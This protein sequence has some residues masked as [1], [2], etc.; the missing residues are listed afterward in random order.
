[1]WMLIGLFCVEGEPGNDWTCFPGVPVN[2][3]DKHPMCNDEVWMDWLWAVKALLGGEFTH[4]GL[5]KL[6]LSV[7]PICCAVMLW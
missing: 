2:E 7:L 6:I 5:L 1:M 3:G 4:L